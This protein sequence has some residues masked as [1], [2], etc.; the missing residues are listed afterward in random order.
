M[1]H[2]RIALL[3]N[4]RSTG[5]IAQLP[6]I[7]EYCAEHPDIF[8]YEVDEVAQI[9]NALKMIARIKPTILV[10]N[11]GDGTV[12]AALTEVHNGGHFADGAPPLAVL[13]SGK[14]NLIA[15]DLGA[16]GDPIA[17]LEKLT[18]IAARD[19]SPHLVAKE[20]IALRHGG[21]DQLPVIGMFL[22]GAGLADIMLYCRHKLYPTGLPNGICHVLTAIAVLFQNIF[23]MRGSYLPPAPSEM[24][25]GIDR[26][27]RLTG[28][29]SLLLVTT[30]DKLL[31]SRDLEG[32]GKGGLKVIAVEEKRFTLLRAI[33]AS[34]R[35]KLG[36]KPLDGVHV[37]ESDE[38]SIEGGMSP[39]ILDGEMFS[40]SEGRPILLRKAQPLSFVKIA[41]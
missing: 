38:V 6:R 4:P 11:G 39:V 35:G 15:L 31:L 12:Q 22:G 21:D 5:N 17:A 25:I 7:R 28:R 27:R 2:V 41:A 37:T 13:P 26:E 32:N 23:G 20:L 3:S 1:E 10:I 16:E 33:A 30:L 36:K 24:G 34:L 9:G 19:L 18:E 40:A 29:F 8:H 14:T